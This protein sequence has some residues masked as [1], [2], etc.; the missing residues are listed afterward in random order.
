MVLRLFYTVIVYTSKTYQIVYMVYLEKGST[1]GEE[2]ENKPFD[3]VIVLPVLNLLMIFKIC[4]LCWDMLEKVIE[5]AY[6]N[7]IEQCRDCDR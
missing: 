3:Y 4:H 2:G 5:Y 6:Q 7:Y 1:K